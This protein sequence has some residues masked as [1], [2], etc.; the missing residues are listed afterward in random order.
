M[1]VLV[2]S[3]RGAAVRAR[4]GLLV[5][6]GKEG[7]KEFS[8]GD[9][10]QVLIMT[11][12]VSVT[13][14]AIRLLMRHSVDV[15]FL[16]PF[17]EAV[18]RV[19]PPYIN[20]TVLTR[21]RQY[22]TFLAKERWDIVYAFISSKLK[23]QAGLLRYYAKSRELEHLKELAHRVESYI[24]KLPETLGN[25]QQVLSLEAQAAR[26]YWGG[27]AELLP[28]SLSF[29]GRDPE[30][31]DPVNI[32]LNYAYALLY[33]RVWR[34]LVLAGLDPYA[35]YLHTDRSGKESLVY[36]FSEMFKQAAVDREVVKVF[37][38][39]WTPELE[40][41]FLLRKSRAEIV[42]FFTETLQR[43]VRPVSG[44]ALTLEQA[45]KTEAF[46]LASYIRGE[47]S[48]YKGFVMVW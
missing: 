43:R 40:N 16:D 28:S 32:V 25:P 39:G 41:G 26:E 38:E 22:E 6:E 13:S 44:E 17:G 4:G 30:S 9:L 14:N 42:R 18:G 20:K 24:D 5:V 47:D 19:Y 21:R 15:V 3:E 29:D 31:I 48:S 46:R 33:S 1:R 7:K 12:G 37:S 2:V 10:D 45:V 11:S 27:V 8:P 36:D 23:N 34:F 35:G